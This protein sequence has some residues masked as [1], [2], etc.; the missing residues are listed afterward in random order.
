M[1]FALAI[2]GRLTR[3]VILREVDSQSEIELGRHI[4]P[5]EKKSLFP[6]SLNSRNSQSLII[7]IVFPLA[8]ACPFAQ[9]PIDTRGHFFGAHVWE[10][11]K[12]F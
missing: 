9:P 12:I 5:A 2:K 7:I 8:H 4:D 10:G 1:D 3:N 11:F 6:N